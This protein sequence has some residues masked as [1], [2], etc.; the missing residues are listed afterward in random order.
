MELWFFSPIYDSYLFKIKVMMFL[1]RR[2]CIFFIMFLFLF[3]NNE[4]VSPHFRIGC[5]FNPLELFLCGVGGDLF[6]I[7][8]LVSIDCSFPLIKV[9]LLK[10]PYVCSI[11]SVPL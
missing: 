4:V 10:E 2:C 3:C 9:V 6:T 11:I 7:D 5:M 1:P 8:L